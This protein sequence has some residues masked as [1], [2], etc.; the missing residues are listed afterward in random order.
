MIIY[1]RCLPRILEQ[2]VNPESERTNQEIVTTVIYRL[3]NN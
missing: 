1:D 2:H 3:Y